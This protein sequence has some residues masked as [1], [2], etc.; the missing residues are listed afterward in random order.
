MKIVFMNADNT[1][2]IEDVPEITYEIMSKQVGGYIE[3][4]NLFGGDVV[5]WVNE[6]GIGLGLPFNNN[7]TAMYSLSSPNWYSEI[8]GNV[9]FT[10]IADEDGELTGV[11]D[12]FLEVF[13]NAY[14][15]SPA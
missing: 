11:S 7:A 12:K 4:V 3:P 9:L 10:G 14:S 5:M 8:L 15:A 6:D 1:A 2:R 13:Q